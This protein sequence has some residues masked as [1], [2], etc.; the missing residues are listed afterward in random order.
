MKVSQDGDLEGSRLHAK[1]AAKAGFDP[2]KVKFVTNTYFRNNRNPRNNKTLLR[3]FWHVQILK[4]PRNDG[5]QWKKWIQKIWALPT[6]GRN[7][8]PKKWGLFS[9]YVVQLRPDKGVL[10]FVWWSNATQRSSRCRTVFIIYSEYN[11][12]AAPIQTWKHE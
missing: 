9:L 1:H 4:W 6:Q 2:P 7:K 5:E 8:E 12:S 11:T 10:P 3:S